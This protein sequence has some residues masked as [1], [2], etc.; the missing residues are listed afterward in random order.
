LSSSSSSGKS[1]IDTREGHD[2]S[3]TSRRH[4]TAS[5]SRDG[6]DSRLKEYQSIQEEDE[7]ESLDDEFGALV[8]RCLYA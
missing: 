8:P 2:D 5:L 7:D 3:S 1:T 6:T 4:G